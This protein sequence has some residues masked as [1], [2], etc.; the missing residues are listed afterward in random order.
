MFWFRQTRCIDTLILG[1][2]ANLELRRLIVERQ[3]GPDI[4]LSGLITY[5]DASKLFDMY[6]RVH[7]FCESFTHEAID[8]LKR[9]MYV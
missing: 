2:S 8:T 7:D 6:V 9:F 4:L 3:A 5:D 1:P